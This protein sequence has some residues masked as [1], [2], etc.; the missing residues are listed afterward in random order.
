MVH[1][2][3]AVDASSDSQKPQEALGLLPFLHLT[4]W[5]VDVM[6]GASAARCTTRTRTY[7]RDGR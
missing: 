3:L 2:T 1:Y 4:N 7:F 5:N 6:T